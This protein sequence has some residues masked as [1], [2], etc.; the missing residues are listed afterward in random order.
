MAGN[1][2][3]GVM[4]SVS[5]IVGQ[6]NA[7]IEQLLTFFRVAQDAKISIDRLNEIHM[8]EDEE[9]K[10][11]LQPDHELDLLMGKVGER[12]IRLE[13]VSFQYS[14]PDSPLV[15]NNINLTIPIGKITAIVGASGSGKTTL[16]KLLLKFYEPTKGSIAMGST[17]LSLI[18]P[19]WWRNQ[20]GV[21]MADGY[22]FSNTIARNISVQED[23]DQQQLLSAVKLSNLESFIQELPMGFS[24][25]I[26]N[27]GNGISS[28]QRQRILIARAIYKQPKILFLDE[29]TST[30]DANNEKVI[31]ENLDRFFEGRT[32]V[33][34]AHR[35][36]TVKYADQIIVLEDGEIVEFGNHADLTALKGKYYKLVKNQLELG[37]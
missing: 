34:I 23:I 30:L 6:M 3:I 18:S 13:N 5:Y 7:P 24:T 16:M 11:G 29:A 26:G 27:T 15:L 36:S 33:V 8:L 35:L 12:G 31:I 19:K 22:I 25:R 2:S 4:L 28:G 17:P 1:I 37:S 14:G 20:C 10:D 21:V 9:K 32:V